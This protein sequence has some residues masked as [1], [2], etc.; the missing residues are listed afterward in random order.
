MRNLTNDYNDC[1][2]VNLGYNR[3]GR[4]PYI[5]RQDGVPPDSLTP[6]EDRFWL[7]KDLTWVINL[8]VFTLPEKEQEQFLFK[9][10]AELSATLEKLAGKPV[11]ENALPPGKSRAELLAAV[12]TTG[13]RL[14]TKIRDARATRA[15]K[16]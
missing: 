16:L 4:G 13:T 9:D 8:T 2:L 5:L 3:D 11:V 6:Q 14:W 10:A 15:A 1:E 12:E 7:R